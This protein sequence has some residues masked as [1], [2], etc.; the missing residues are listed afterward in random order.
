MRPGTLGFGAAGLE[1]QSSPNVARYKARKKA[2][3]SGIWYRAWR[4]LGLGSDHSRAPAIPS[5][6]RPTRRLRTLEGAAVSLETEHGDAPRPE[7]HHLGFQTT[8]AL[9]EFRPMEVTAPAV[10]LS[11]KFVMPMPNVGRMCCSEG[12]KT[13]SVKPA[14]CRSFQNRLPDRAKWRPSWPD[15]VP[16][17]MPQKSS[18]RSARP[19]QERPDG[20]SQALHLR[21]ILD[22]VGRQSQELHQDM[23]GVLSDH[24]PRMGDPATALG[25]PEAI[26]S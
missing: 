2:V 13:A 16:G 12:S 23:F 9:T 10:A 8:S 14:A 25:R 22:L 21:K 5:G 1:A 20:I 6:C 4:P 15:N 24:G 7:G 11:T 17:L 3:I 19:G 26:S 18:R